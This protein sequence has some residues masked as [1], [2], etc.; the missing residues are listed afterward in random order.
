MS[1]T[2]VNT[3]QTSGNQ[4]TLETPSEMLRDYLASDL[5]MT[6]RL[7][8]GAIMSE[9]EINERLGQKASQLEELVRRTQG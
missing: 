8:Q 2:P 9:D 1:Q 5:S 6:E 3:S 4:T 7:A